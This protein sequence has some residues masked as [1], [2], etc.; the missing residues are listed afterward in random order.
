MTAILPYNFFMNAHQ[1][2]YYKLRNATALQGLEEDDLFRTEPTTDLQR[3]YEGWF[4]I[5]SG[6]ACT[7]GALLN[8]VA[9]HKLSN[10]FRVLS[11]HVIVL[12]SLVP[13]LLYTFM[14]TDED[15]THFF[16]M[17]MLIS[18]I[19]TLGSCGLIGAGIS[20]LA[21]TLSPT[22]IETVLIA[23]AVGGIATSLLSIFCQ[24][25]TSNAI[26]D[27]RIYFGIAFLWTIFSVCC[28]YF[29]IESKDSKGVIESPDDIDRLIDNQND[30][31]ESRDELNVVPVDNE[32]QR[33]IPQRTSLFAEWERILEQS[34]W[35]MACAV[36]VIIVTCAAFPALASRVRTQHLNATWRAYF[37]SICC[38]LLYSCSDGLGRIFA[39]RLDI[40][41]RQLQNLSL[42]R[43]LLLPLIAA[44]D[45]Q[46]RRHS[47]TLIR[48]DAV[49]VLLNM[50]LA[51][52]N[53]FCYTHAYVKAVQSVDESLRETAGSMMSLT[54]NIVGLLGCILGVVIV[55]LM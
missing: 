28:Y 31:Q 25:A 45:V 37:T 15:Q 39:M 26:L 49:F 50:T 7:L 55:A 44:C 13:T 18:S 46:P 16:W 48:F 27:G 43:L 17:T 29:V 20:G 19:A 53:G 36:F 24:A 38:F 33:A 5:T 14:D 35:D 51:L 6:V 10:G 52:S 12:L 32:V 40:T 22:Y 8:T 42:A 30:Q 9:T 23:S 41:R 47:T 34:G 4:T 1:Y 2:F 21:A 3:A 54:G 11:G